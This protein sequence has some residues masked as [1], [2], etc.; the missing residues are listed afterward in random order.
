MVAFPKASIVEQI[1][2]QNY[3]QEIYTHT[4]GKKL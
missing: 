2:G 3:Q 1:I 4:S